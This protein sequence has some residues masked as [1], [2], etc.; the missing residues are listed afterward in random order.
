MTPTPY[1]AAAPSLRRRVGRSALPFHLLVG[2]FCLLPGRSAAQEPPDS[3]PPADTAAADSLPVADSLAQP[4]DTIPAADSLAQPLDTIPAADSLAQ[5]LDTIPAADS[6]AQPLD[7]IPAADSLAQPLDTIPAA[8]SLAQPLDTIPAADSL[9]QPLDTIPAADSLAQPLDTIPAA[10]SLAQPLDTIPAADSLAQPLDTI[11]A[12]DSLAQPLDSLSAADSLAVQLFP[13]LRDGAAVGWAT[14]VWEWNREE[15]LANQALSLAQLLDQVPGTVALRGGDFGTPNTVT[16]FG[17][18]GGRVRLFVDGFELTPLRPGEPDLAQV[19]LAGFQRVRVRRSTDGLRVEL[20]SIE[21]DDPRPYSLVEVGTGDLQTNMLRT[22]FSHPSTLG[23]NLAFALDRLDTQGT[24]RTEPGATT[25][26]WLRYTHPLGSRLSLRGELRRVSASRPDALYAPGQLG[27]SDW[28]VRA[29][30]EVAPGLAAEIFTGR[31][32]ATSRADDDEGV[33]SPALPFVRGQTGVRLAFD[34]AFGDRLQAWTAGRWTSANGDAWPDRTLD[35]AGGLRTFLGGIEGDWSRERWLGKDLSAW[36]L[37]AWTAPLFGLSV[38]GETRDGMAG[39]P[40]RFF[41][42]RDTVPEIP[43]L[44]GPPVSFA[45][46]RS[47]TRFGAQFDWRGLSLGVAGIEIEQDRL[48]PFGFPMD[49]A[50]VVQEGG[51]RRGRE[52]SARLPLYF[53]GLHASASYQLWDEDAPGWRYLPRES[54]NGWLGYH[55]TFL[56]TGNFEIWTGIGVEGRR[57]MEVPFADPGEGGGEADGD[58]PPGDGTPGATLLAVP[59]HQSWHFRLEMRVMTF[60]L[61]VLTENFTAERELQ[62]FPGRFLPGGRSV[63]GIKWT[64][65]N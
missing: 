18:G 62:D 22:T 40:F 52:F 3:V 59:Y 48:A 36:S 16:A 50:G 58:A 4:L 32:A 42:P 5:P 51:V 10:D 60:R 49:S 24:G 6:L 44:A 25:G 12:A 43:R 27:R 65:W 46:E 64:L 11:P 63:Y 21:I 30:A 2:L 7:T 19:G 9:A 38:F 57:A 55:N 15:L 1:P 13:D 47:S 14:G 20:T 28:N 26:M 31:S 35:A 53:E 33:G 45:T 41:D 8:D 61:F 34:R 29:R 56:P 39:V 54:W 17:A 23:G 37:R